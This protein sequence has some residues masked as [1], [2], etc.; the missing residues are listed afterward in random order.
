MGMEKMGGKPANQEDIGIVHEQFLEDISHDKL[1]EKWKTIE[2]LF[3]TAEEKELR[4]MSLKPEWKDKAEKI[5]A[6]V[7]TL[8]SALVDA[9]GELMTGEK[10]ENP[11]YTKWRNPA[12]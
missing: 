10:R 7:E 8:K 3:T 1:N 5:L 4:E 11:E 12:N 6:A 2:H 9:R